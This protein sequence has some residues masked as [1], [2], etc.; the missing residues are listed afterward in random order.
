MYRILEGCVAEV[1]IQVSLRRCIYWKIS[2]TRRVLLGYMM[3]WRR[4]LGPQCYRGILLDTHSLHADLT[5]LLL[6]FHSSFIYYYL[7][8]FLRRRLPQ[9]KHAS[10][11]PQTLSKS[12]QTTMLIVEELGV[13]FVAGII[14]RAVTAPLS[15]ITVRLQAA[16]DEASYQTEE[17]EESIISI[18]KRI[19]RENGLVGF[20]RGTLSLLLNCRV[21]LNLFRIR[22]NCITLP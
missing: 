1:S 10:R 9:N 19:Y 5:D 17:P 15:L 7:Y 3:V 4:I 14:S 22:N 8:T 11:V 16:R 2:W 6:S 13:G 21:F 18:C 20:W 12:L